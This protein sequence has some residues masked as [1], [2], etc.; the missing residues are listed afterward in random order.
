MTNDVSPAPPCC[1]HLLPFLE[2]KRQKPQWRSD[3]DFLPLRISRYISVFVKKC[4]LTSTR[5]VSLCFFNATYGITAC[6]SIHRPLRRSPYLPA[7]ISLLPSVDYLR[8]SPL[9]LPQPLLR[10]THS[11]KNTHIYYLRSPLLSSS[12]L[13]HALLSLPSSLK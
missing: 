10:K 7:L 8:P 9:P 12:L 11:Q 2:Q 5:S 1:L 13:L 6:F 3:L 4:F